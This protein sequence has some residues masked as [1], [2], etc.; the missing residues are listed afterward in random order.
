MVELEFLN[1]FRGEIYFG[2]SAEHVEIYPEEFDPT[3]DYTTAYCIVIGL[4]LLKINIFLH[5]NNISRNK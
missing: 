5:P 2:V 4:I 3:A 1:I